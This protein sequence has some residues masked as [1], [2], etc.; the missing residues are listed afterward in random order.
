MNL[1]HIMGEMSWQADGEECLTAFV[2]VNASSGIPA[3][4]T[5]NLMAPLVVNTK[6]FEAVQVIMQDSGYSCRHPLFESA[7]RQHGEEKVKIEQTTQTQAT[8]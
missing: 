5:A 1:V 3:E 7:E 6:R 4:M 2:L 8:G